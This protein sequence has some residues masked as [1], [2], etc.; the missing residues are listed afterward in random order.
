MKAGACFGPLWAFHT[1]EGD[2]YLCYQDAKG[3]PVVRGHEAIR[4][5]RALGCPYVASFRHAQL[6]GLDMT[7]DVEGFR[8]EVSR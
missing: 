1:E 7:C 8:A 5:W 2:G 3:R 4:R 6:L